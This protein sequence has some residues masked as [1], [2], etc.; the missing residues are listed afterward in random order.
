[1]GTDPAHRRVPL[2]TAEGSAPELARTLA[3]GGYFVT[4]RVFLAEADPA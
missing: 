4:V 1:M 2:S 3:R